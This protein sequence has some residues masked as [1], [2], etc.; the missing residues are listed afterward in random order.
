ML[1]TSDI[2]GRIFA[3]KGTKISRIDVNLPY[4]E[5]LAGVA[6]VSQHELLIASMNVRGYGV[7]EEKKEN[8]LVINNY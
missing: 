8:E 5:N 1:V 3:I 6:M 4:Y 2:E 7:F